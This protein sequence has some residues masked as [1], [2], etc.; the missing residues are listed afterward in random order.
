MLRYMCGFRRAIG[1]RRLREA[2]RLLR[3]LKYRCR[4][5]STRSMRRFRLHDS[6][7]PVDDSSP[8]PDSAVRGRAQPAVSGGQNIGV[9]VVRFQQHHRFRRWIHRAPIQP[10][11]RFRQVDGPACGQDYDDVRFHLLDIA[12]KHSCLGGDRYFEP[13]I[14]DYRTSPDRSESREG[15]PGRTIGEAQNGL[16]D[17]YDTL[18]A[19]FGGGFGAVRLRDCATD[20]DFSKHRWTWARPVHS[21]ADALVRDIVLRKKLGSGNRHVAL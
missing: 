8:Y 21:G 14:F 15:A 16:A 3:G 13:G 11:Y 5:G 20:R 1:A 9:W 6:P 2:A 4:F 10:D 7:Q 18:L 19:A 17:C 12:R